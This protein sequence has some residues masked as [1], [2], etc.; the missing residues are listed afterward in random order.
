[1]AYFWATIPIDYGWRKAKGGT[2]EVSGLGK[3]NSKWKKWNGLDVLF[4]A[5][6]T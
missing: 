4:V 3:C 1:V 5:F 2:R 6:E